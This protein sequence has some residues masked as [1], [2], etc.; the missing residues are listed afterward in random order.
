MLTD[1]LASLSSLLGSVRG[2]VLVGLLGGLRRSRGMNDGRF[3][4]APKIL[5][6]GRRS[7]LVI[8]AREWQ[9]S[10]TRQLGGEKDNRKEKHLG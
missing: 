5:I 3:D 2:R 7:G 4:S 6:I 9:R 8:P 1:F 10:D